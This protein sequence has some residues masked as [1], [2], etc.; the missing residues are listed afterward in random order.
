MTLKFDCVAKL[1]ERVVKNAHRR[2]RAASS[3]PPGEG[4]TGRRRAAAPLSGVFRH[5]FAYFAISALPAAG[6][7][8]EISAYG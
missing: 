8:C 4:G 1:L 7:D 5:A 3:L 6:F 2:I